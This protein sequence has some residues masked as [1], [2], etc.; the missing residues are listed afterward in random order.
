MYCGSVTSSYQLFFLK[1]SDKCLQSFAKSKLISINGDHKKGI[2]YIS[3][4]YEECFRIKYLQFKCGLDFIMEF[5]Q[6]SPKQSI[7]LSCTTSQT[8]DSV[9]YHQVYSI[10]VLSLKNYVI[11]EMSPEGKEST[12]KGS[13]LRK[14]QMLQKCLKKYIYSSC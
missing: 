1:S 14:T 4:N 13:G 2:D 5:R 9:R 8:S 12:R 7:T 6:K 11:N 10:K 3:F